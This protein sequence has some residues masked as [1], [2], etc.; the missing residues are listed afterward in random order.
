MGRSASDISF[1]Q[2]EKPLVVNRDVKL[3]DPTDYKPCD[4]TYRYT[5]DGAKVRVSKRTGQI[6]PIPPDNEATIDYA[7]KSTYKPGDKDTAPSEHSEVTFKAK[8]KTFE[9]DLMDEYE[10]EEPKERAPTFV[11]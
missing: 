4:V 6:I 10:I 2:R 9:Q 7:K 8:Y 5:E 11:Y 3:V 1:Q